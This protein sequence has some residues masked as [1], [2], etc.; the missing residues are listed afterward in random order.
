MEWIKGK[1]QVTVDWETLSKRL[2]S[3]NQLGFRI[4]QEDGHRWIEFDTE[5]ER[6]KP[7][8]NQVHHKIYGSYTSA[9]DEID[10]VL[11]HNGHP[12]LLVHFDSINYYNDLGVVF[13][14]GVQ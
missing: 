3:A 6:F 12:S 2:L 14:E 10:R 11:T 9:L 8:F 4:Y 5:A 7:Y 13:G 1:Q